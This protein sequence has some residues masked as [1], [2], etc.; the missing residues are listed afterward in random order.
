MVEMAIIQVVY[1]IGISLWILLATL[2][3]ALFLLCSLFFDSDTNT[4]RTI[5]IW[6][7]ITTS[8]KDTTSQT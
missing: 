1:F 3:I 4:A 7:E 6:F 5:N 8:G 2:R